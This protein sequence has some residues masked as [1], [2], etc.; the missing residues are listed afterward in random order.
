M[1]AWLIVDLILIVILIVLMVVISVLFIK[2][3]QVQNKVIQ[4]KEKR[5]Y[6]SRVISSNSNI[7]STCYRQCSRLYGLYKE[8]TRKQ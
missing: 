1:M 8:S 2:K 6:V 5:I 7:G 3:E 4:E